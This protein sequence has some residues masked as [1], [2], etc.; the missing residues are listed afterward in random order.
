[1]LDRPRPVPATGGDRNSSRRPAIDAVDTCMAR[2]P[3]VREQADHELRVLSGT[4]HAQKLVSGL[5]AMA[6]APGLS[7]FLRPKQS[8]DCA[9][10]RPSP[11]KYTALNTAN[12]PKVPSS[13]RLS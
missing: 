7:S 10:F 5:T 6:R 9:F 12:E 4:P 2:A 11:S 3:R 13:M 1:M 8:K